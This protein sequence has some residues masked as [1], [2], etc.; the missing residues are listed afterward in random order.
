[1]IIRNMALTDYPQLYALWLS[2]T[3]MG[4]NNLDDSEEGIN[5]FLKRNPDT[6]FVAETNSKII[7]AILAGHDGRRGYIYHTAV[8]PDNRNTGIGTQLVKH[9][10]SAFRAL[11]IS[12]VALVVFGQ[13]ASGNAFWEGLGFTVRNDL[14]YRDIC[15]MDM[16]RLDT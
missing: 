10:L 12:K 2:S 14:L 5:R 4:L 15:L 8:L 16:I 1:M 9:V 13:N 6:C 11:D 7:G 3:G